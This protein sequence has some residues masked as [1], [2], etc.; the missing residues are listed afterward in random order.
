MR[1]EPYA[2]M[3][4]AIFCMRASSSPSSVVSIPV[5]KKAVIERGLVAPKDTADI[6]DNILVNLRNTATYRNKGYLSLGEILMLDIVATNAA[7]GWKRPIYWVTTVGDDYHVGLTP[8]MRSTGMAHQLV[9][10]IQEGLPA[11]ADRAYDVVTK[12]YRWG[13]ADVKEGKAP[14][15]DETARRMLLTTR[16][17][18]LDVAS[19]LV[20]EGDIAAN[21]TVAKAEYKKAL[22]VVDL[23]DKNLNESTAPYGL[24]IASTLGQV[25][26]EL[27]DEKRLN[28]KKLTEKG[29]GILWNL[30]ERYAPY[31]AYNREMAMSFG[32]P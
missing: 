12:K 22:E 2:P 19:E 5:D 27:G 10:T 24:S 16:S 23:L 3:R 1:S 26:C 18:M 31:L 14:Y 30:M 11:R 29:L 6:V 8:Y 4:S 21:D 28:D 32:N 17:S 25:Y 20:Y 7:N 15:F 13:G 9:P